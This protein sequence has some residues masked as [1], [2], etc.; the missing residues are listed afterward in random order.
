ML[1]STIYGLDGVEAFVL[2]GRNTKIVEFIVF[3]I[4]VEAFV[5]KGRN[6]LLHFRCTP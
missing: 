4:G 3:R 2:K 6:T 5:L 1:F